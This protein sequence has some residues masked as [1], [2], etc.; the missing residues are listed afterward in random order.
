EAEAE[1]GDNRRALQ[2]AA[3]GR[4]RDHVAPA[5]DDVDMAGVAGYEAVLGDGR[6]ADPDSSEDRLPAT[7]DH[8]WHAAVG[9]AG[10]QR[11][12][13]VL[14]DELSSGIVVAGAEQSAHR[15][16]DKIGVAIPGFAI[17]K[18]ELGAFGND[19]NEIGA[20]RVEIVEIQALQQRE[21]L[22]QYRS[23]APRATL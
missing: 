4:R 1:L 18:G 22:Q 3:A 10:A 9:P 21:L 13:G 2:P 23:L 6:L 12:R 17:G 20:Q 11:Q 8:P 7:D 5:V 16:V 14:A 19:V 15:Y